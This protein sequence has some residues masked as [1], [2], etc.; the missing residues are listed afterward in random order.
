MNRNLILIV[1]LI[2]SIN[3]TFSQ[4]I[5]VNSGG[6]LTVEKNGYVVIDGNLNN[7]SATNN[8]NFNSDSDE[9][10]SL[11]VKGNSSQGTITY[12]RWVNSFDNYGDLVGSPLTG[13]V[14]GDFISENSSII[15]AAGSYYAF[16]QY[17]NETD[18]WINHD[19][20]S[21]QQ[22]QSGRGYAIATASGAQMS[23]KG[24]VEISDSGLVYLASNFI[25]NENNG[26]QWVLVSNPYP[27]Y[28]YANPYDDDSMNDFMSENTDIMDPNYVA[29][30][31]WKEF[32]SYNYQVF[33]H[34]TPTPLYVAPGQAFMVAIKDATID[35]YPPPPPFYPQHVYFQEDMQTYVG[36]DDFIEG[37]LM[38]TETDE[39]VL[40][41]YNNNVLMDYTRFYF[42]DEMSLGLD[43]GYDAGHFN[44][45]A[46]LMSR[47]PQ[48]DDGIGFIINAMSLNEAFLQPIPIEINH[49][50]GQEF[51]INLHSSTIDNQDVYLE[52]NLNQTYTLL[53]EEDFVL[54][55]NSDISGIGRFFIHLGEV[56][57]S[58][59][60]NQLSD[61]NA[62]KKLGVDY[63]QI[64][65]VS[66]LSESANF[67][68]YDVLG[69]L[70]LSQELSN[71]INQHKISTLNLSKGVYLLNISSLGRVFK[72]KIIVD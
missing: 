70:I 8:V 60:E 5:T 39:I 61:I 13:Q 22:F 20:N 54:N 64:E 43:P 36:G 18:E 62:Y 25:G 11:I 29:I 55:P 2:Y 6:K 1:L 52:D 68:L 34:T 56:S 72:K 63:I 27:S 66:F 7:L 35:T 40:R 51:R 42:S 15:D 33:N 41:L 14:I 49:S 28:I 45:S 46:S 32:D 16:A 19:I 71:N 30:Y 67:E 44:Q 58:N 50:A 57:L 3:Y 47:L 37:D 48:A 53:N 31:G 23:F 4:N 10:S 21:T 38:E 69:K 65:G 59:N 24:G 9:F 12:N 26:S 17:E